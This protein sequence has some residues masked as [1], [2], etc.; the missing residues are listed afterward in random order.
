MSWNNI[1]ND[2]RLRLW[3]TLRTDISGLTLDEQMN[4]VAKFFA[5]MPY[6]TR[7]LD[8]YTP[9]G[10]PTPWEILFRSDLCKSAIS[11][12]IFYTFSLISSDHKIELHLID[13]ATDMYLVPVID[14]QFILNY[15]L[16]VVSNYLDVSTEYKIT[17]TFTKEQIKQI[18]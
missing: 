2:E 10:W 3:K 8:Y 7:T 9:S 15:E 6:T 11:L 4:T 12:L 18:A 16:G 17:K 14:D 5:S 1:P 13:D